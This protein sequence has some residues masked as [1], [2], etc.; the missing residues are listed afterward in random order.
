[1][2]SL[3]T[4]NIDIV[5][6]VAVAVSLIKVRGSMYQGML[7]KKKTQKLRPDPKS[8]VNNGESIL[9]HSSFGSGH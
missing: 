8:V 5:G 2:T 7:G 4:T 9:S 3:T 1:V 6:A